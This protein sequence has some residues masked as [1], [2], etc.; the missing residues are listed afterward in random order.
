MLGKTQKFYDFKYFHFEIIMQLT[1]YTVFSMEKLKEEL[2]GKRILNFQMT[3]N[4]FN[5]LKQFQP[6]VEQTSGVGL[7]KYPGIIP[8]RDCVHLPSNPKIKDASISPISICC[9]ETNS[10]ENCLEEEVGNVA[11]DD[12]KI[13]KTPI[14]AHSMEA[15]TNNVAIAINGASIKKVNPVQSD[16]KPYRKVTKVNTKMSR[17]P[18]N[19]NTKEMAYSDS[20][21]KANSARGGEVWRN[22]NNHSSN[23]DDR[24]SSEK[25]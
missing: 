1:N 21:S 3:R 8:V 11:D 10:E 9:D 25:I 16:S 12:E 5:K 17:A 14:Q 15:Q 18:M 6:N 19:I 13:L 2:C 22:K 7:K 4:K 23:S 20:S 24:M